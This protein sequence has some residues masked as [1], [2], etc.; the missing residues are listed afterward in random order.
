MQ[1]TLNISDHRIAQNI[2]WF[3]SHFKSDEVIITTAPA[4]LTEEAETYTNE[5]IEKHWMTFVMSKKDDSSY[6]KSDQYYMDRA[7]A[8]EEKM[9]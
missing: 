6:Y 4:A 2:L 7:K 8:Y 3:L 5:Y 1:I 9:K